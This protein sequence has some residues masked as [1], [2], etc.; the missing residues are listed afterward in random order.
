MRYFLTA[1]LAMTLWLAAPVRAQDT[2]RL[3]QWVCKHYASDFHIR[4]IR[5]VGRF[6]VADMSLKAGGGKAQLLYRYEPGRGWALVDLIQRGVG[7]L[8]VFELL[9]AGLPRADMQVVLG[10]PLKPEEV[11]LLKT[12]KPFSAWLRTFRL[13]SP[14]HGSQDGLSTDPW[15]L[16]LLRNEVFARHGRIFQDPELRRIFSER[17]WYKPDP[18]YEESRLNEIEAHNVRVLSYWEQHSK[19]EF[20]R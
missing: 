13:P 17:A 18:A 14:S 1:I 16:M 19:I 11:Q 5:Q 7:A 2:Q 9:K 10:R 20:I 3:Y 8:S 6:A 15:S 4:Q 12:V